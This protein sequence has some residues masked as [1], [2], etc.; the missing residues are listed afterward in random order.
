MDIL[1]NMHVSI[2]KYI[3]ILELFSQWLCNNTITTAEAR[4]F[5]CAVVFYSTTFFYM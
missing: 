2:M 4:D 1:S 3:Y 5:F